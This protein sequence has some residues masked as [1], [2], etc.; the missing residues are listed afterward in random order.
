M[1]AADAV[2]LA[3]D[4]VAAIERSAALTDDVGERSA[5]D[6][7]LD[8]ALATLRRRPPRPSRT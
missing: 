5:L 1:K 4:W 7:E 8:Q 3:G 2:L 6:R